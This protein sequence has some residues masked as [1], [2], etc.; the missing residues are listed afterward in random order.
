MEDSR[1]KIL[2]KKFL[3]FAEK[4]ATIEEKAVAMILQKF[5]SAYNRNDILEISDSLSDDALVKGIATRGVFIN[6]N[7]YLLLLRNNLKNIRLLT[8]VNAII[9]INSGSAKVY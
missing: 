5:I 7:D 2:S 3:D 9:R 6:K 1:Q 4:P 8:F